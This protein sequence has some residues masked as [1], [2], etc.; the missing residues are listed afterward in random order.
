M[1]AIDDDLFVGRHQLAPT[2][3]IHDSFHLRR[4]LMLPELHFFEHNDL[5]LFLQIDSEVI[6]EQLPVILRIHA[7]DLHL[8]GTYDHPLPVSQ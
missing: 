2:A 1:V 8:L 6:V 5:T 7:A 4:N 3:A